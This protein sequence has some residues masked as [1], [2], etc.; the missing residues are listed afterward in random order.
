MTSEQYQIDKVKKN[1]PKWFKNP[2]QI[3]STILLKFLEI[4]NHKIKITIDTLEYE[5]DLN[6]FKS[7]F[8]K[9]IDF[10][11]KNNGKVFEVINDNIYLW[12]KLSYS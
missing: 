10:T 3:N 12:T 4:Q 8:A 7:N 6:T 2:N 1:I 11:E 9:M 5:C